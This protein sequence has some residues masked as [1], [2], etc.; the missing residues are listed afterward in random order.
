[1]IGYRAIYDILED[2]LNNVLVVRE[3]EYTNRQ[4]T[5]ANILNCLGRM[6]ILHYFKVNK[7][8]LEITYLPTGQCI[9][10]RGA[11]NPTT[12]T[13]ITVSVGILNRLYF[14]E[15][16]EIPSYEDFRKIDGSLR[17]MVPGP[18]NYFKI[19]MVLNGWNKDHWI[20]DEF[21][22]DKLANKYRLEDNEAILEE[23]GKQEYMDED[24][25]GNYGKGLYLA[26]T[27]YK[28][29]EF[30]DVNTYDLS[31]AQMKIRSPEIWR[32][33]YMGMWGNVQ[34]QAYPEF[35]NKIIKTL[36]ECMKMEFIDFAIGVDTGLSNGQGKIVVKD[37]KLMVR[38]ATTAVLKGITKDYKE[39]VAL[40]EYFWTNEGKRVPKTEPQLYEEIIDKIEY[41]RMLF[42]NSRTL[43]KGTI[44]VYVDIADTGFRQGLDLATRKRGIYD[45]KYI[46][47][48][49]LKIQT[50]ID[51]NRLQ[52]AW[53]EYLVCD[54]CENLI[55]ELRSCHV[56][57]D[58]RPRD[59]GNDHA[60]NADEYAIAP[61]LNRMVRWKGFKER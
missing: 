36:A 57:D 4:S 32:V 30:R 7:N 43:M 1:M 27:N 22:Y 13:S 54:V 14:E 44:Y 61:N 41:W 52:M 59:D 47:S 42:R 34:G 37:G 25:I 50:R 11:T 21:F 26:T 46:G 28:V 51:F 56:S 16:F 39:Q 5:F 6:G 20:H 8:P 45:V 48:T 9:F 55:R 17:G 29:N 15:A 19:T 60:I 18:K 35:S 2:P 58:G 24:F 49:K 31:A 23:R 3:N 10:F 40:G 38:S 12:I 53:E 33:E